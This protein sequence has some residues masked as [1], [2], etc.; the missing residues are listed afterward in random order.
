MPEDQDSRP[1]QTGENDFTPDDPRDLPI[2]SHDLINL[3]LNAEA[4]KRGLT[5]HQEFRRRAEER[6]WR[7]VN[8]GTPRLT[9]FQKIAGWI[10]KL[11]GDD[12]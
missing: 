12:R 9:R 5:P 7:V 10:A 2:S 8:D 6:G 3:E 11:G 1:E 4:Q